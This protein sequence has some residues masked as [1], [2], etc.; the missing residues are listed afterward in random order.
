MIRVL[1]L[2]KNQIKWVIGAQFRQS[3]ADVIFA[4]QQIHDLGYLKIPA[5]EGRRTMR[6][7]ESMRFGYVDYLK[8]FVAP[9]ILINSPELHDVEG[10]LYS[11]DLKSLSSFLQT[12][13]NIFL[14]H[15][16]NDFL[17]NKD[18]DM[19]FIEEVFPGRNF[20]YPVGGHLG[21]LLFPQNV[22]DII[23][24]LKY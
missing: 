21:N 16:E 22:Q 24:V 13:Q 3:L 19:Q 5:T 1:K 10:V 8:N 4:S 6:L 2:N 9:E 11:A 17:F 23:K 15:N 12:Q 14:M 20:L 7:K 18:R